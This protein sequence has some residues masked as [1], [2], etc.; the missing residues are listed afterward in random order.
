M[1]LTQINKAG[2]DEL[3][4]DHVFTIGASGYSY[5]QFQ[6]EG[7]NGT[8]NNPTLYLTRGK[9]Y[10]FENTTGS[11]AIRIQ[12]A[13]N[14]TSGT[15]YNTGVTNNNTTGTVIV[16]VQHDAPDVLYYQ[17]ANHS[18]MK[19]TLYITGALADG[20][21]TTAKLAADA[22]TDAKIADNAVR[23]EHI[24]VNNVTTA[25]IND[26][27]VTTAKIADDAV[28][29]S[30]IADDAIGSNH[31]VDGSINA[32]HLNSSAVTTSKLNNNAVDATKIADGA[33][34]AAKLASGV[35]TTI[36]NNADNR[37]ITGSGTANTLNGES[38]L[39]F[40][41]T[42]LAVT[43]AMNASRSTDNATTS[44]ITNNGTTGGHCLK[45][46]SGGTGAGTS[47]FNVFRNNQS[48]EEEVFKVDGGGTVGIGT[49]TPESK[50]A[51]KGTSGQADLFSISD[52]TVP[53][54]GSEYGVAMIKTNSQQPALNV[55][56][57][58]TYG[59]GINI[60][61]NG[62]AV[63]RDVLICKQANGT[64]LTVNEDVTVNTGNLVIGTAGKGID[65]SATS[66]TPGSDTTTTSELL[67]DYEEG[68][69]VP[70]FL[71]GSSSAHNYSHRSGKYTRIGN[72]VHFKLRAAASLLAS[73][74]NPT[75]IKISGFPFTI[76]NDMAG[77]SFEAGGIVYVFA[78]LASSGYGALQYTIDDVNAG[79][80][81]GHIRLWKIGDGSTAASY[82]VG[83]LNRGDV[84]NSLDI[85]I[86]GT[87]HVS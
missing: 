47:I 75:E 71:V 38:G 36:N 35:Q 42:S 37:V 80:G 2:L 56:N 25:K 33:V 45:L 23:T 55:T 12:S 86:T 83:N 6:G 72:I 87:C 74:S 31:Y 77:V 63:G 1:T 53:T 10:R 3:A 48:S 60:Y 78:G 27:A 82:S 61:N 62:G 59:N 84:T 44:V 21:V 13:D 28:T 64:R 43:G 46:T 40:D 5:Y 69:F 30:K 85:R 16:E 76:A 24:Q 22:I 52:T 81:A 32:A 29:G 50:L 67:D 39:T 9:T 15:L 51:I 66:D 4:L 70:V 65:F 79:A 14:G 17:C 57:Y 20:S 41:G 26:N 8:V 7:L 58:N 49:G 11:H 18:N 68:T 54:S 19:G 73:A 34:T